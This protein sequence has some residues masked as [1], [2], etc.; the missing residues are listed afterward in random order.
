MSEN[1]RPGTRRIRRAKKASKVPLSLRYEDRKH[2]PKCTSGKTGRMRCEFC[3]MHTN[4]YCSKCDKFLCLHFMRNCYWDFHGGSA[5]ENTETEEYDSEYASDADV[6]DVETEDEQTL[7]SDLPDISE[8]PV[9]NAAN[10]NN[11]I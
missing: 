1:K 10:E 11:E 2:L 7:P 8:Q 9:E 4:T 3:N 6:S 5:T